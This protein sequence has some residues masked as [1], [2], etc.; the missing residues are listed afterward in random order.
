MAEPLGVLHLV[1][2]LNL[3][4]TERQ[5]YEL[6]RRL[7]RRRFRPHVACFHAGGELEPTLRA[8]GLPPLAL[9]LRGTL[10]RPNTAVQ[11]ARLALACRQRAVRVIHAHDFYSNLIGVA[12]ARLA[13]ARVIASRRDLAHWLSPGRRR[14][15]R[16]ALR[17][18]DRVLANA[19]AVGRLALREQAVPPSKLR[20]VPNGIDVAAFDTIARLA[21]D[22]PLPPRRTGVPRLAVVASMHRPDKGHGDLLEAAARLD[23][24]GVGADWLL[25]S[26]GALRPAWEARARALGL[27]HAIHFLGRR[28][29][30]PAVL[31]HADLIVHPSWS[32]GFPN[33]VLE[34]MCAGR[35]VVATD[36]GG[37]PE[38][39]EEGMTGCLV[40]PHRPDA[41]TD[42]IAGMLADPARLQ[43]MG[44]AARARVEARFS[45]ERM[46]ASVEA[47]Y[48]ELA[49]A[50]P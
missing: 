16:S 30:V 22:P 1:D 42:A 35:P 9:P 46:T 19:E 32:E 24:R 41:L 26:D 28:R 49:Q 18:A 27:K 48:D 6:L 39:M 20:V 12:A 4:G 3:G 36:V 17:F 10:Y 40:P 37:V 34:G 15:L 44:R 14:A 21:P 50:G 8:L 7:D 13:G 31:A 5:L 23:A 38:V 2:C 29:D 47:I 43:A 45:V 25:L 11:I 33:A